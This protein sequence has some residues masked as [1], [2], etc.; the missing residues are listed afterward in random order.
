MATE[1][2]VKSI[3]EVQDFLKSEGVSEKRLSRLV[4]TNSVIP[5][6]GV[7]FALATDTFTPEGGEP[8][9]YPV[10]IIHD[11]AGK[12]GKE[13]GKISLSQVIQSISAGKARKIRN[14]AVATRIG[15]FFHVG[16]PLSELQ[17]SSEAEIIVKLMGKSFTTTEVK[18]AIVP[19]L[20][21]KNNEPVFYDTEADAL[22]AVE[23]KD[24]LQFN[25]S[26]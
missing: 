11:K 20:E 14:S 15:K 23:N 6:S 19:K 3:E 21:M 5:T 8:I 25:I 17:G 1:K 4:R 18:D 13:I 7:F 2:I 9:K 10:F 22:E 24:C 16:K 12:T 26:Y